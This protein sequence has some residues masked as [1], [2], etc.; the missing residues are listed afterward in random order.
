MAAIR[1]SRSPSPGTGL[2]SGW[3]CSRSRST[4][5]SRRI[6]RSDWR[7]VVSMM[8]R[9]SR[10]CCGSVSI[11]MRAT[12]ERT[13]MRLIAWATM[14]WSSR[15]ISRSLVGQGPADL[16][17]PLGRR[18]GRLLR[19]PLGL[20]RGVD[21][22]G[23]RVLPG[24]PAASAISATPPMLA[25]TTISAAAREG[26]GQDRARRPGRRRS[27]RRGARRRPRGNTGPGRRRRPSRRPPA[28]TGPR[29]QSAGRP[30]AS[31]RGRRRRHSVAPAAT[32]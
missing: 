8:D 18:G 6:S 31:S 29:P 4:P 21:P 20:L 30:P 28:G 25:G 23:P 7:V 19:G 1:R 17:G 9:A 22:A 15:A 14:S 32:R 26:A 27:A 3:C 11:T 2:R 10:A 24:H 5:T 12:P 16:L 13:A